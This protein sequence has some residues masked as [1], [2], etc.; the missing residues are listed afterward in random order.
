KQLDKQLA[1]LGKMRILMLG[2]E[3]P[4]HNSGGL[5]VACYHLAKA[6]SRQGVAIDFILPKRL[7][8]YPEV[9]FMNVLAVDDDQLPKPEPKTLPS[10]YEHYAL[11]DVFALQ[12]DYIGY[13]SKLVAKQKPDVIHAHDWLTLEAGVAAKHLTGAPLIAHIHATEFDRAAGNRGNP[14]IHDIEQT[15]LLM[16]DRI[17]AVSNSTKNLIVER[18]QIPAD[19]IEV[20]HNSAAGLTDIT[21]AESV[22]YSYLKAMQAEGYLVVATIGRLTMQKGLRFFLEAAAKAN[23][24]LE[25]FVFVIAGDGEQ[26]DELIEL[27][28]DLGIADKVIFL[29][30]IRGS[31][32]RMMYE[33]ADVFVMSS[34]S[35]PFGLTALEAAQCGAAISLTKQS[36]VAEILTNAL[37][38]DYWDTDKLTDQLVNLAGSDSLH[39]ELVTNARLEVSQMSW[40]QTATRLVGAYQQ[41]RP[42]V[43]HV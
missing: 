25:R 31:A 4:P 11:G 1:D 34:V 13:V 9:D 30:F 37:H 10:A 23:S 43:T 29:G 12:Q 38:Y 3:L 22:Q 21:T 40:D 6:L 14:I 8:G 26:R 28:A 42:G 41:L 17:V 35:E 7:T 24:R 18:Y 36:G 33:V 27:A 39:S 5:G 15:G 20:I 16:A 32:W 19:K 2:W